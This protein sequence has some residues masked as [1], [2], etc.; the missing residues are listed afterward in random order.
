[1]RWVEASSAREGRDLSDL[2]APLVPAEVDLRGLEY[3]PLLGSRLFSSN[4]DLDSTD[5]EFRVGLKLWWAAWNQ[6][7]AA[8]LP[9]EENRLRKLAGLEDNGAKWR[10]V[11][12][13]AL[14]GFIE[15]SDG[16]LYHP[17]VAEQ[18]LIAWERRAADREEREHEADRK[19]RERAERSRMFEELRAVGVVPAWN[20]K[21]GELRTLHVER[22]TQPVRVTGDAPVTQPVTVTGAEPVTRTV[23]AKT[24]RD[25][26]GQEET[27]LAV[28]AR[29]PDAVDPEQPPPATVVGEIAAALRRG[30]LNPTQF[31]A[32][33]TRALELHRQGATFAE[34]EGLAREAV[35]KGI[36]NPWPWV[37]T[38]LPDRRSKAAGLVLS[39][40]Q[41]QQPDV[42]RAAA[43]QGLLREQAAHA[44]ASVPAPAAVRERLAKVRGAA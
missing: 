43:T 39:P 33:D 44:L 21:T 5:S 11:R 32:G 18:A 9:K 40:R 19:R 4:F 14:Q 1:M 38:V 16:R 35:T 22:V 15:C 2:P 41:E 36:G 37:L 34:F 31:N 3:M 42:D 24:G 25:G 7:P 10:K 6:V 30:G 26:T 20:I 28:S 12:A 23:T 8:S 13:R 17:I 29:E 27:A